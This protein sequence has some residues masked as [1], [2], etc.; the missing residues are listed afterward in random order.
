MWQY[1]DEVA[2]RVPQTFTTNYKFT[3]SYV[4]KSLLAWKL[5]FLVSKEAN[6]WGCPQAR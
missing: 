2:T 3:N 6:K 1:E 4:K 5:I